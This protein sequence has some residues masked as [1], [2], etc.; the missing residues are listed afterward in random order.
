MLGVSERPLTL[1]LMCKSG[2]RRRRSAKGARSFFFVFGTRSVTFRSLFLML[3]SLFSRLCCQTPFVGLLLQQ[4]EQKHSDTNGEP[5]HDISGGVDATFS[6]E[7]GILLRKYRNRN[8]KCVTLLLK[9]IGV[10]GQFDSPEHG[11]ARVPCPYPLI[12]LSLWGYIQKV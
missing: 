10:R 3:L 1:I 5:Y 2:C 7:E 6:Q 4:G 8:G 12:N 11:L 9:C